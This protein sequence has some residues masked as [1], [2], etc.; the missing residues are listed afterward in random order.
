MRVFLEMLPTETER[1]RDICALLSRSQSDFSRIKESKWTFP[2]S[3]SSSSRLYINRR[4]MKI[5]ETTR[6]IE[7]LVQIISLIINLGF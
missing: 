5:L 2:S 3:D 1:E 7:V 6:T 4:E